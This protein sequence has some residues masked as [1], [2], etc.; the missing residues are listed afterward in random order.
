M[1]IYDESSSELLETSNELLQTN[2]R[3]IDSLFPSNVN[4]T[5]VRSVTREISLNDDNARLGELY[6]NGILLALI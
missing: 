4:A 5:E 3:L 2:I 1:S 6:K